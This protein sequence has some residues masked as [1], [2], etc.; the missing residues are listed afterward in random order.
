MCRRPLALLA[1]SQFSCSLLLGDNLLQETKLP[2]V[3]G[4]RREELAEGVEAVFV[5][6]F[7]GAGGFELAA[8]ADPAVT[9][10]ADVPVDHFVEE[11]GCRACAIEQALAFEGLASGV[12]LLELPEESE[13]VVHDLVRVF[14]AFAAPVELK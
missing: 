12:D 11:A 2:V 8:D 5:V 6:D 4:N 10:F 1:L 14:V 7:F 13:V 9:P 3:W